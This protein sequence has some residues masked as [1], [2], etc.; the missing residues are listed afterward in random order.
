MINDEII[1]KMK[2]IHKEF[3]NTSIGDIKALVQYGLTI[4]DSDEKSAD[5]GV[6]KSHYHLPEHDKNAMSA[7]ALYNI[8][9]GDN[10]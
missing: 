1:L 10:K 8:H 6:I 3:K 5:Q 9:T 7:A 2:D 4:L